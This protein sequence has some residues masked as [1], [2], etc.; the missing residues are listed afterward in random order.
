[1]ER[2]RAT[3]F[4]VSIVIMLEKD[5]LT[6]EMQQGFDVVC[7]FIYLLRAFKQSLL[8]GQQTKSAQIMY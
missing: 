3:Q 8:Y 6:F 2:S 1:M 4:F 5:G 7:F